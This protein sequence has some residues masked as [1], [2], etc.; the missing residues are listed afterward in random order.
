MEEL[1]ASDVKALV[2]EDLASGRRTVQECQE[3]I[4]VR[5]RVAN[6]SS[7]SSLDH[8]GHY[9]GLKDALTEFQGAAGSK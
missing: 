1:T 3:L 4:A 7:V 9:Q 2:L 5:A 6:T 8:D